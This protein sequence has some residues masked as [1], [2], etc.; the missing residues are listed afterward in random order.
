[1]CMAVCLVAADSGRCMSSFQPTFRSPTSSLGQSAGLG[2]VHRLRMRMVRPEVRGRWHHTFKRVSNKA[3]C[4]T[5]PPSCAAQCTPTYWPYE[6][7]RLFCDTNLFLLCTCR[8]W[9]IGV[10]KAPCR[11]HGSCFATSL[12]CRWRITILLDAPNQLQ[13]VVTAAGPQSCR[14]QFARAAAALM[15]SASAAA[16]LGDQWEQPQRRASRPTSASLCIFSAC[17]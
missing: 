6:S 16:H 2:H 15:V 17:T 12:S 10:C 5:L 11:S 4:M 8:A 7:V 13:R 3:V 9:V 1:M 14:Q